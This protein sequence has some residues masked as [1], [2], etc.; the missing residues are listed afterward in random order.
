MVKQ[1]RNLTAKEVE[2]WVDQKPI[3]DKSI[4]VQRVEEPRNSKKKN[5][6]VEFFYLPAW[7]AELEHSKAEDLV[8]AFS[9]VDLASNGI[10]RFYRSNGIV[11]QQMS[12]HKVEG[13]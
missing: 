12:E 5:P 13:Y 2:F 11:W 3:D 10:L 1:L 6:S 8:Q 9:S 7:A 4:F